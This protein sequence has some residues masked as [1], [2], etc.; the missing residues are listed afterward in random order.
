[1]NVNINKKDMNINKESKFYGTHYYSM[2]QVQSKLLEFKF[3]LN[4]TWIL[5]LLTQDQGSHKIKRFC[6]ELD[7][8]M[9]ATR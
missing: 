1:M 3:Y 9:G 8:D 4:L 7:S 6:V 5:V 2:E